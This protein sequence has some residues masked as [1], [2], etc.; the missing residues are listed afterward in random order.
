MK[1]CTE[2]FDRF[3]NA[4]EGFYKTQ[5]PI[6]HM[7]YGG[8]PI[9]RSEAR[10]LGLALE[11]FKEAILDFTGVTHIGQAFAHE[12]FVLWAK[13]NPTYKLIIQNEVE[14]VAKMI[15]RVRNTK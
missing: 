8:N 13:N 10:R 5:I 12:L 2:V 14:E 1:T 7:F 9:S 3:S 6:A 11:P 15:N 4:D